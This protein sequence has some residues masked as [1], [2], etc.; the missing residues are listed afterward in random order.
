VPGLALPKGKPNDW[1]GARRGTN[2]VR[3]ITLPPNPTGDYRRYGAAVYD[4][5]AADEL[6]G[7]KLA[8]SKGRKAAHPPASGSGPAPA[9]D[10]TKCLAALTSLRRVSTASPA[11]PHLAPMR[12]GGRTLL[13]WSSHAMRLQANFLVKNA[14]AKAWIGLG[15]NGSIFPTSRL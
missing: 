8:T 6:R 7:P 4:N 9:W 1:G 11:N 5:K 2:Y 10:E 15:E 3:L 12:E 14:A 13:P